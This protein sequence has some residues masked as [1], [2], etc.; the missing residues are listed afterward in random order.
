MTRIYLWQD[1]SIRTL[2]DRPSVTPMLLPGGKPRPTVLIIPGGGYRCVCESSEGTPIGRAF[3]RLGFQAFVL[4]YRTAPSRWP[5]PQ[6]DAMRAM[7]LIRGNAA[8]WGVD[9][10]RVAVCGFSAGAHLAGSLG[11]ICDDLDAS[12]GDDFDGMPHRPDA[13]ILCYGVLSFAP[14]SSRATP[15]NLLGERKEELRE[16]CSLS[17][18]VDD[19]TPP[20]FLMH[21]ISDQVVPY[22]NSVEFASAM[23]R[24]HRPCELALYYWGDHGMLLGQGTRDMCH[25]P[26]RARDFLLSLED[27]KLAPDDFRRRYT[28]AYQKSVLPE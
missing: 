6:L 20:T 16:H 18:R 9:P 10:R 11:I 12:G 21:T 28:N 13:M 3:N 27:E 17:G 25:W 15:D 23:A 5:L 26:E 4:D 2:A 24:H 8:E 19:S 14:W 7:K 22:R 1:E